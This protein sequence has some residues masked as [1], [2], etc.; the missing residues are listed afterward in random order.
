MWRSLLAGGSMGMGG[1]AVRTSLSKTLESFIGL[2]GEVD[3]SAGGLGR[4]SMEMSTSSD[5]AP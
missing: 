2:I 3:S 4:S 1:G 5:H